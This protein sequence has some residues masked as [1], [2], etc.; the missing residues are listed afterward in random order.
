MSSKIIVDNGFSFSDSLER[1]KKHSAYFEEDLLVTVAERVVSA[2]KKQGVP[3]SGLA[4]K[5][6]VSPAY[7]TKILRG[8]ANLGLETLA[9]LAFALEMKWECL[10]IPPDC[11][12]NVITGCDASGEIFT[13]LTKTVTLKKSAWGDH[14]H[15]KVPRED[16]YSIKATNNQ[17]E[18]KEIGR[19][20]SFSA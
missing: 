13:S 14:L 15:A 6:G 20:L 12:V 3:R 9:K 10:L 8:Q 1:A 5:M 4:R 18:Y 7:I 2:M 17:N 19:E 11:S 16:E